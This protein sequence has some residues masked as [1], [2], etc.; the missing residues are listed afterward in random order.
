M[1]C[2]SDQDC[3]YGLKR[4]LGNACQPLQPY[5]ANLTCA[6]DFDC[7]HLGYYCPADPTGGENIYWVQ[8]CR[9][10][11]QKDE[12]CKED[13]ECSP[14]TRCNTAEPQPR[15]RRYFSLDIGIPSKDDTLCALG[16][17]DRFNK[18]APP[19]KSKEAGRTCDSD[20]D[21]V[22]TDATGRTGSCRC[23]AWWDKDDSK[24]CNPVTGDYE[25]HWTKRR[26]Y[27]GFR[28][29][30]CGSFWSEHECLKIW[31]NEAQV[32]K[33]NMQCE[34]QKLS[35]GPYLPPEDCNVVDPK[36]FPDYC[37]QADAMR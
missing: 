23:K 28:A 20:R 1:P 26:D 11:K 13:R 9:R 7:P 34:T 24:Y 27:V 19:A 15:C 8:Y 14:D 37:Q 10:Q 5:N 22:T 3:T 36:K 17:R 30:K 29:S 12:T 4:C 16:W 21:C 33:L 25:D 32:L 6:N 35:G 31:G 18:C 2:R